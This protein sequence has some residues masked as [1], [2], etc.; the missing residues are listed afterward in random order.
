MID[1]DWCGDYLL[2][3]GSI[4]GCIVITD[5]TNQVVY[6]L[7]L[8]SSPLPFS[9]FSSSLSL[10][11]S[12]S[13]SS[14]PSVKREADKLSSSS[15]SSSASSSKGT[16]VEKGRGEDASLLP[17]FP[18]ADVLASLRRA[19]SPLGESQRAHSNNGRS[20]DKDHQPTPREGEVEEVEEGHQ[21][22]KEG[23]KARFRSRNGTPSSSS[24]SPGGD[25]GSP[26]SSAP[27]EAEVASLRWNKEGQYLAIVDSSSVVK[28]REEERS[29]EFR[30]LSG[31]SYMR[32]EGRGE[33][34]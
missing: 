34:C 7:P 8:G 20:N 30:D 24:A 33:V 12:S 4:D 26:A 21:E 15:S 14:L 11:F 23:E 10:S 17:L 29:E 32:G 16:P 27:C 9:A 31:G 2:A 28:V 18:S 22:G 5:F 1:V 6:T 3:S 13:S 19:S 25:S